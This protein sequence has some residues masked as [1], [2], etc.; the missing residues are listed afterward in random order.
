LVLLWDIEPDFF[1]DKNLLVVYK[2]YQCAIRNC[3]VKKVIK[4]VYQK[5]PRRPNHEKSYRII[6]GFFYSLGSMNY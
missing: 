3:S 1:L 4:K 5:K 2:K 6:F